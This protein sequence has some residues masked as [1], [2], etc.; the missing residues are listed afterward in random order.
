MVQFTVESSYS[1]DLH[2]ALHAEQIYGTSQAQSTKIVVYG[3]EFRF[4]YV[5][6]TDHFHLS[7]VKDNCFSCQV[8]LQY[9]EFLKQL[10]DLNSLFRSFEHL[11]NA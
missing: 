3:Y 10:Q 6:L 8:D 4:A 1:T 2:L 7:I 11:K 5:S 9:L